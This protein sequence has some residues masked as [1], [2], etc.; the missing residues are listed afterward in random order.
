MTGDDEAWATA[1]ERR[2][3][4]KPPPRVVVSG[5]GDPALR[6]ALIEAGIISYTDLAMAEE[7]LRGAQRTGEPIVVG[8]VGPGLPDDA[9]STEAGTGPGDRDRA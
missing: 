1:V 6:I 4:P 2:R 8:P 7:K 5:T 9:V 3:P